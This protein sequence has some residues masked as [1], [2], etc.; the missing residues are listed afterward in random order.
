MVVRLHNN[1]NALNAIELVHPK[2]IKM[3]NFMLYIFSS[4]W[5]GIG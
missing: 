5:E 2:L 4:G 3:V 1:K